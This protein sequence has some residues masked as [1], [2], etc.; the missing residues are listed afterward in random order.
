MLPSAGQFLCTHSQHQLGHLCSVAD[1]RVQALSPSSA[2][3]GRLTPRWGSH[4]RR[5][6]SGSE[7]RTIAPDAAGRQELHHFPVD[8]S[9][10]RE[11]QKTV[12][13]RAVQ[14]AI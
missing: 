6:F 13:L 11:E 4:G 9:T 12:S 8:P 7:T 14:G 5:R 2:L 10:Q 3:D 1:C